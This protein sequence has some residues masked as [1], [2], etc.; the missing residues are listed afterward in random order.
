MS[1]PVALIV[2]DEPDILELLDI[3]LARMEIDTQK[4]ADLA[5]ARALLSRQAFD[6]CLTDMRLPDGNGIDLVKL[7]S[8]NHPQL[9][10]AVITAHG[11]M[12]SAIQALKAG[13]FDFASKP[14]DLQMLRQLVR[15][16]LK[17]D[18]REVTTDADSGQVGN[19]A[20]G[21]IK[22]DRAHSRHDTQTCPQPGA[23]LYQRRIRHRQGAGGAADSR[24]GTPR[25][26]LSLPR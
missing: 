24:T 13:A 5:Q 10:V 7:I 20:A 15:S 19:P 14:I 17:L 18:H 16:A 6:L 21:N 11:N 9:P 8:K 22:S 25:G 2:D 4:A 26:R 23:R 3:T 12:E 1:R